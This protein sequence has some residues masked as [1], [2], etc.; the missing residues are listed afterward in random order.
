MTAL[1]SIYCL[2]IKIELRTYIY[3]KV[4]C[5]SDEILLLEIQKCYYKTGPFGLIKFVPRGPYL[6]KIWTGGSKS[7]VTDHP[8]EQHIICM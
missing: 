4:M 6:S 5:F 1:S 8:G 3:T 2:T 7:V